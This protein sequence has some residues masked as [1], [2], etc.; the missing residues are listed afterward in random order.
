VARVAGAREASPPDQSEIGYDVRSILRQQLSTEWT[1]YVLIS[2]VFHH[3]S[4]ERPYS[5]P[6]FQIFQLQLLLL[7]I[8]RSLTVIRMMNVSESVEKVDELL[9]E[10]YEKSVPC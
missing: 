9:K 4:D 3:N 8:C 5:I 10:F 1:I 6:L 2:I 7:S